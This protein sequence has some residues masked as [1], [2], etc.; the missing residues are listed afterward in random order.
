MASATETD[1]FG[2]KASIEWRV[3]PREACYRASL[4]V[5]KHCSGWQV[6]TAL[7]SQMYRYRL[8][9]P[10]HNCTLKSSVALE[11][12]MPLPNTATICAWLTPWLAPPR[13]F[14][15]VLRRRRQGQTSQQ[16]YSVEAGPRPGEAADEFWI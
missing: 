13:S 2:L 6:L 1:N 12:P 14:R 8:K 7:G 9:G 11:K 16:S 10:Y 5:L 15:D 3:L 4:Y